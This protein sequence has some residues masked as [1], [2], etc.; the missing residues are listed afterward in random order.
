MRPILVG[1]TGLYLRALGG[2][3]GAVPEFPLPVRECVRARLAEGGAPALHA[4][5]ARVDAATAARLKPGDGQRIARALEVIE[6]TGRSL[7]DFQGE[8][9]AAA[10]CRRRFR[11][12]VLTPYRAVW[13]RAM[14][15]RVAAMWKEGAAAEVAALIGRALPPDR[16]VLKA[17]GLAP[18]AR[19][20]AGEIGY[21]AAA[22]A[23]VIATR[24]YAKRQTTWFAHQAA[25]SRL[26]PSVHGCHVAPPIADAQ[27]MERF[28]AEIITLLS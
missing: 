12:I 16:P 19:A 8:T 14:E 10:A 22:A 7:L 9:T 26:P 25:P 21:E 18:L 5:L 3:I 23:T 6:A 27:Q 2:G 20:L 11:L 17:L 24:Q 13:G 28:T 15:T 4:A 1:G